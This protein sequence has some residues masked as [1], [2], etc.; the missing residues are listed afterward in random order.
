MYDVC[1]S[2]GLPHMNQFGTEANQRVSNIY[3]RHCYQ[4]GEF[5]DAAIT[6][7]EMKVR[8]LAIIDQLNT[9]KLKKRFMKFF[10]PG[11]LKRTER[12]RKRK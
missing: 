11:V 10:Y 3:C 9:S 8:G 7:N 1:Q 6:F 2:C 12:W 5:I 4:D